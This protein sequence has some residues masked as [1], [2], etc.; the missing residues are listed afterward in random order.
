M[1]AIPNAP[2]QSKSCEGLR[3]DEN[4]RATVRCDRISFP[5]CPNGG[6]ITCRFNE[7]TMTAETHPSPTAAAINVSGSTEEAS[8]CCHG[9]TESSKVIPHRIFPLS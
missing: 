4:R 7:N 8:P 5:I 2:I 6:G 3:S 1:D 9:T